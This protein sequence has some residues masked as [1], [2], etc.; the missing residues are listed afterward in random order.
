[1]THN[2]DIADGFRVYT[3]AAILILL[4]L[5]AAPAAS[6]QESLEPAFGS[7]DDRDGA[8]VFVLRRADTT[9]VVVFAALVTLGPPLVLW[10]LVQVIGVRSPQRPLPALGVKRP[11]R[12]CASSVPCCWSGCSG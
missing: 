5:W 6:A 3:S 7:S 4:A 11:G 1:M 9:D 12:G 10:S 2:T 8:D